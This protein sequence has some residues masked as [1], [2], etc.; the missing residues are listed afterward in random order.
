MITTLRTNG[1]T[2]SPEQKVFSCGN[3]CIFQ[4]YSSIIYVR[5]PDGTS[6]LSDDYN[7]SRTTK[8]YFNKFVEEYGIKVPSSTITEIE[9]RDKVREYFTNNKE[10]V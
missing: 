2:G 6:Y 8:K 9:I 10:N 5:L 3:L 1:G 7:Y 4:S